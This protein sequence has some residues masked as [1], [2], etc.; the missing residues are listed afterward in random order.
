MS[1]KSAA[2]LCPAGRGLFRTRPKVHR[3]LRIMRGLPSGADA[4]GTETATRRA[5]PASMRG[6]FHLFR[7]LPVAFHFG[8]APFWL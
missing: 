3:W 8:F 6:N 5:R 4:A 1:G 2:P 7:A